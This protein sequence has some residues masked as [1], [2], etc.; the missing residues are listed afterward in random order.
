FSLVLFNDIVW[1]LPFALFLLDGTRLGER[2]R[3][4]A[5]PACGALN[6]LAV[7]AIAFLLKPGTE[8]VPDPVARMNYIAAHPYLWRTG[9]GLWIVAAISLLAFYA[10]WGA[11]LPRTAWALTG[12]FIATCG[13][14]CDLLAESLFIGWLPERMEEIQRLGTILTGAAANGLYTL[15]G[16]LLTT[17]TASLRGPFRILTWTVWAAGCALTATALA[18]TATGMAVATAVLMAM[19]C[20]WA[21]LMGRRL[22]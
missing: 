11:H 10:W 15:A 14:A 1:W 21:W 4:A 9:W 5:G 3:G 6:A 8:V 13:A 12:L 19:F 20:P 7:L 22:M 18:A 2:L 16:V 17:M